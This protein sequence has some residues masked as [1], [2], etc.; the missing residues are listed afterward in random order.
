MAKLGT[1]GR[2]RCFLQVT[3]ADVDIIRP[4]TPRLTRAAALCIALGAAGAFTWGFARQVIGPIAPPPA[5]VAGP[6]VAAVQ[7]PA[8]V[9][10]AMQVAAAA[11]PARRPAPKLDAPDP[12]PLVATPDA[13]SPEPITT[14]V[15]PDEPA[16]APVQADE[17]P[18]E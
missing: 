13:A 11:E 14:P 3:Y 9:Q 18:M 12:E 16:A 1:P 4:P 15:V 2:C 8:L 10:P 17:P 6:D 5:D 7:P